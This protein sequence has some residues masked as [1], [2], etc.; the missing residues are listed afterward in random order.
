MPK[1]PKTSDEWKTA[2]L[3]DWPIRAVLTIL[4]AFCGFVVAQGKGVVQQ[5]ILETVQPSIDSLTA[6]QITT[7]KKVDRVDRK[8]DA[9]I[10]ILTE[11]FP[12]VKKAAQDRAVK[13][14]A[15]RQ[16]KDNLTGGL[17]Q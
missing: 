1:L 13:E 12:E 7:E 6:K 3:K 17:A 15:D 4:T 11:A 5:K 8:V 16:L 9:L 10:S 2:I 14:A